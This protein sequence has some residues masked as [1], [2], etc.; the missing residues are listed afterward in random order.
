M[1]ATEQGVDATTPGEPSVDVVLRN[2]I[3]ATRFLRCMWIALRSGPVTPH[4][5]PDG[6]HERTLKCRH[7]ER[8]KNEL[9]VGIQQYGVS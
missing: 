7:R 3:V 1:I 6:R 4:S 2:A 9:P 8:M 5:R